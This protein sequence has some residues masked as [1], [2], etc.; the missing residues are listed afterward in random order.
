MYAGER[1]PQSFPDPLLVLRVCER[2]EET[3]GDGLGPGF[4][5][6]GDG[7]LQTILVEGRDSPLA[8]ILSLTVKRSPRGASV[9][10]RS[11]V[12]S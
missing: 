11:W 9:G 7:I 10:G 5:Y 1:L 3:D 2:E 4:F 8:P 6:G 12:R